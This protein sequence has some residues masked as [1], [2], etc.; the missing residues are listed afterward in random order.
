MEVTKLCEESNKTAVDHGFWDDKKAILSV[1]ITSKLFTED[2]IKYVEIA[3]KN[4]SL[5]LM[6]S[7]LGEACE[8]LR[9]GTHQKPNG[10]WVKST[11]EDELC[12]TVIRIADTCKSEGI[13]LEWQLKNKMDHNKS[14]PFKHGKAF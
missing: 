1:M 7:E 3:F 5:M 8:A 10:E 13:D 11:Y 9:K 12:D 6:V 14:R 2:Q 4:Q